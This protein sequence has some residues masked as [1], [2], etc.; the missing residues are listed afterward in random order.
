M[1]V[2]LTAFEPFGEFPHN[3]SAQLVAAL[4][5]QPPRGMTLHAALLPVDTE[6]VGETLEAAME[7]AQPQAVLSF[8]LAAGRS[9]MSLERAALNLLDFPIPDNQGVRHEG[10]P[11]IPE[12]PAAYFSTLPLRPM[13][14]SL[15]AAGIPAEISL[16][17]GAYLCNQA[18]YLLMHWSER[19]GVG[20]AGFVHLP[21]TPELSAQLGKL[22]PSMSMEVMIR[23]AEILLAAMGTD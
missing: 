12:S 2:L 18:F 8:G 13:L 5:A 1:R 3:P 6:R 9:A 14:E 16:S 19:F 7:E 23:G 17:A 15:K 20:K 21:C 11:I 10:R 22:Q 4:M